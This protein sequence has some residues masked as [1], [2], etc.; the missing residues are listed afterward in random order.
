MQVAVGI[1]ITSITPDSGSLGGGYSM[2]IMGNNFLLDY[3][4]DVSIGLG[5]CNITSINST[6]IKCTVP[7]ISQIELMDTVLEVVVTTRGVASSTCLG[8]CSFTYDKNKTIF[9]ASLLNSTFKAGD[10]VSLVLNTTDVS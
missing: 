8:N 10:N 7:P 1:F 3:Q 9:T 2:T 6:L 5:H 4:A